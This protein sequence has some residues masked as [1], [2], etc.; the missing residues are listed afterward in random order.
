[1][2]DLYPQ[3]SSRNKTIA[4]G[5]FRD[6]FVSHKAER[7]QSCLGYRES[8]HR[9]IRLELCQHLVQKLGHRLGSREGIC[10]PSPC[11]AAADL[12]ALCWSLCGSRTGRILCIQT[13]PLLR[14]QM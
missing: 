12:Q 11:R 14:R 3:V 10:C 8:F 6:K 1:M 7:L 13:S 4:C 2:Q 9:A 5:P